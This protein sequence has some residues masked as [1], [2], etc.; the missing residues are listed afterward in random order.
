VYSNPSAGHVYTSI[1]A[2]GA[3]IYLAGYNGI[4]STIEKFILSSTGTM[5]TLSSAITAAELPTGEI[6]Q[7]IHYYLGY[8]LIGTSKGVRVAAS[9]SR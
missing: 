8:M 5:P 4:Q 7:A 3:A 2:S 9:K 1:T 6:V